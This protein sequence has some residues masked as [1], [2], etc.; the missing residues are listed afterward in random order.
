MS[1]ALRVARA[2][3]YRA[4]RSRSAWIVGACVPLAAAAR[5]LAGRIGAAAE[6][7]DALARGVQPAAAADVSG[8]GW[9]ALVDGW[10]VGLVLASLLLVVHGARALAGDRES[11]VLRVAVTRSASRTGVVLGRALLAPALVLLFVALA[12][13]GAALPAAAFGDFGPLV[14]EGYELASAEELGRELCKSVLASLPALCA[15][16]TF[17]LFVGALVRSAAGATAAALCAFLAFDLFKEAL[18]EARHLVFAAFAPTLVDGSAMHEMAG[19]ARGFSDAGYSSELFAKS[20][21]LPWPQAAILLA[22]A[23]LATARRPL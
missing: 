23:A 7:A 2:E 8:A 21:W 3:L 9:G 1:G 6:R 14:E 15:T 20:L 17:G 22:A 13:A 10:R 18:G 16:W 4:L 12:G 11:G 5:V 19:V